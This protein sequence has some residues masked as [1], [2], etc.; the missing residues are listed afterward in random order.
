MK[1]C[2]CII[3][4]ATSAGVPLAS[5]VPLRSRGSTFKKQYEN[6]PP[7]IFPG[8]E[9]MTEAPANRENQILPPASFAPKVGRPAKKRIKKAIEKV[10]AKTRKT[11]AV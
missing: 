2:G 1:P 11:R 10:M 9:D 3:H 7:F 6:L 5:L 8:D 4:V